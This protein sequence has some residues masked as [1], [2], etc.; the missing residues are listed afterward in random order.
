[1]GLKATIQIN[2][3]KRNRS[4]VEWLRFVGVYRHPLNGRWC[5]L[6]S[7]SPCSFKYIS[8]SQKYSLLGKERRESNPEHTAS[9]LE[10]SLLVA[11]TKPTRP[12]A[13]H[14][15]D[16]PRRRGWRGG[17]RTAATTA[18]TR[19]P[20]PPA[21]PAAGS[22]YL[23]C[24]SQRRRRRRRWRRAPAWAAS[25]PRSGAGPGARRRRR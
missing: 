16:S 20:A 1:M 3:A 7:F 8:H 5:T 25:R 2:I 11:R 21:P 12:R 15:P 18:T 22:G 4:I 24:G 10:R 6:S 13:L 17:A 14:V 19:A 9:H 23:A